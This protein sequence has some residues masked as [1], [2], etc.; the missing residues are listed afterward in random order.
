MRYLSSSWSISTNKFEINI[1]LLTT[2]EAERHLKTAE[3]SDAIKR[4]RK[5]CIWLENSKQSM[6]KYEMIK[7]MAVWKLWESTEVFFVFFKKKKKILFIFSHSSLNIQWIFGIEFEGN[8]L[9]A[10][11]VENCKKE[12]DKKT[13]RKRRRRRRRRRRRKKDSSRPFWWLNLNE[14]IDKRPFL[15]GREGETFQLFQAEN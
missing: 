11:G 4:I 1:H 12:E 2:F 15:G 10:N 7:E 5:C 8:V 3:K 6:N 9:Q 14:W 13:K